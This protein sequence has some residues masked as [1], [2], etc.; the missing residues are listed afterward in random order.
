MRELRNNFCPTL[1]V[2]VWTQR[3]F[4]FFQSTSKGCVSEAMAEFGENFLSGKNNDL[5]ALGYDLTEWVDVEWMVK[6]RQVT[7]SFDGKVVLE[8]SYHQDVG[9][10]TGIA[11]ISNGLPEIDHIEL[12][13]L[14]GSVVYENDFSEPGL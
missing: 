10:V 1:M 11:F 6:N 8:T 13:G 3:Y 5:S 2:E 12:K 7:V 9:Y 4:N 14:D